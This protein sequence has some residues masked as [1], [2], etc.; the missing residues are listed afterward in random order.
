MRSRA[1]GDLYCKV[2]VETPVNLTAEQRELLEKFEATFVGD[3]ARKHSPQVEHLPRWREGL[4]GPD[5]VVSHQPIGGMRAIA[6]IDR[7]ETVKALTVPSF[8]PEARVI[9]H[10]QFMS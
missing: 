2:V 10:E 5:G 1:P 8:G 7:P 4:L 9:I 3:G 6:L